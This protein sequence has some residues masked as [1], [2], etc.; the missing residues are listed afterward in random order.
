MQ[1]TKAI[2]ICDPVEFPFFHYAWLDFGK[3]KIQKNYVKSERII[4]YIPC[5]SRVIS[6]SGSGNIAER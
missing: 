3:N 2:T 5:D 4:L 1:K 6:H